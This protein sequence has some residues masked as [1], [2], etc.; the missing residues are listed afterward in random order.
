MADEKTNREA[1]RF[2]NKYCVAMDAPITGRV[3]LALADCLSRDSRTGARALDWESEPTKAALPLRTVGGLHSLALK[4]IALVDVFSGAVTDPEDVKAALSAA[5][6]AHDDALYHWLDGPPQTNEAGR[7]GALMCG[8]IEVSRRLGQ[9]LEVIEI[10]SS[11][12]LNLLIDRYRFDLGGVL[13]GPEASPVTI[14]PE[15]R[16][17]PPA[18]VPVRFASVRGC[19]QAPIDVRD[20]AAADR[21]RAY[22]WADNPERQARMTKAIAMI[23]EQPVS[24]E[25][26]DAA[27]WLEARLAEP[28]EGGVTRVL[29]HSVVWQYLPSET[30]ARITAMM[31]AAG[32]AASAEKPLAWVQMEPDRTLHRQEVWVRTWPDGAPA[33]MV[34]ASQAHGAWVEGWR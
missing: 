14:R 32:A 30:Q 7:S 18:Q 15:W 19:D 28:Q 1:Y 20:P 26:A 2:Q 24:L 22:V 9:P 5:L 4:G 16:G 23:A 29:M 21:L 34:A 25:Q 8:L 17:P 6:I 33:E 12:G 10:G 3:V 31:E 27:D 11:A 13:I